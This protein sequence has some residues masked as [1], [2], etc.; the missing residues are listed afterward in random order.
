M[1][2]KLSIADVAWLL[3]FLVLLG[4]VAWLMSHVRSTTLFSAAGDN[5]QEEWNQWREAV[6][7]DKASMGPVQRRVPRSAEP[8]A[9]VLLRDY[10]VVCLS[11]ALVLSSVLFGAFVLFLRGVMNA[12]A[13][14][15]LQ[16]PK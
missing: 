16:D 1:T 11:G 3:L 5:S 13:H 15:P 14:Q 2:L 4:G 8:P 9:L 12:P 7:H 6:Q 10:F